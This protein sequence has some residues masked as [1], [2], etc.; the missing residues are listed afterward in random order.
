MCNTKCVIN[1]VS[2]TGGLLLIN[3]VNI[4][5]NCGERNEVEWLNGVSEGQHVS[6]VPND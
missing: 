1:C 2:N 4:L 5:L 3:D 6:G